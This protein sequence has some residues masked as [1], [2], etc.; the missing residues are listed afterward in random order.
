LQRGNQILLSSESPSSVA[1][2]L[3]DNEMEEA[4]NTET[5][6]RIVLFTGKPPV[7]V[8]LDGKELSGNTFRFNRLDGTISLDIPSRQ[9]ELKIMFR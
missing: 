3:N 2:H 4:C 8:L 6:A 5:A 1:V 9:H 7:R